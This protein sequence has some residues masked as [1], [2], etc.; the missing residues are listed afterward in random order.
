MLLGLADR[1]TKFTHFTKSAFAV[2]LCR[3]IVFVTYSELCLPLRAVKATQLIEF[4]IEAV[5]TMIPRALETWRYVAKA[6]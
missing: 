1:R 6:I 3:M 4:E 5:W 2:T